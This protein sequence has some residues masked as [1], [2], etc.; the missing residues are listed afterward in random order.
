[1]KACRFSRIMS[2][3]ALIL[4]LCAAAPLARASECDNDIPAEQFQDNGWQPDPK[5]K[6][7]KKPPHQLIKAECEGCQK[8]YDDLQKALDD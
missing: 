7:K 6:K 1:M 4:A 2:V 5:D 8:F 3:G